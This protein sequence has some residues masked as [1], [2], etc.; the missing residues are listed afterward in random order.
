MLGK[1]AMKLIPPGTVTSFHVLLLHS[2]AHDIIFGTK[3]LNKFLSNLFMD[4]VI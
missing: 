1:M 3:I 2:L 4:I